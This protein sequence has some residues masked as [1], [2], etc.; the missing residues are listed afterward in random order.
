MKTNQ[1]L[2]ERFSLVTITGYKAPVFAAEATFDI[3]IKN[4][5]VDQA[6]GAMYG[7]LLLS[8]SSTDS[9]ETFLD[10]VNKLGANITVHCSDGMVTVSLKAL[11]EN[12]KAVISLFK[13][14]ITTPQ[15]AP[16][17][18]I[19]TKKWLINDLKEQAEDARALAHIQLTTTL[20]TKT[21]RRYTYS[22]KQLQ[23][24]IPGITRK[25][26][27]A[28]HERVSAS[29]VKASAVGDTSTHDQLTRCL[30]SL[31]KN[32]TLTSGNAIRKSATNPGT[33]QLLNV[34]SR[35]NIEYSIGAPLPITAHHPDFL[36]FWFGLNVLG[37]WGGFAGRLMS[38]VR[39]KEGLTYGIYARIES[40]SGTETSYWRIMS[41]FSPAN[42]VQGLNSTRREILKIVNDGITENELT[43]F[44]TILTTRNTLL[45]DSPTQAMTDIHTFHKAGFS[46][47]ERSE[48]IT[49]IQ[50][51]TK[52]EVD[53]ALKKYLKPATVTISGAGPIETVQNNLKKNFKCGIL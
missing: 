13:Q 26:L 1:I 6:L 37:K 21:D 35:Q 28:F 17:E 49:R 3:H 33:L 51:L 44:K 47:E 24:I 10:K 5:M 32:Q 31:P 25:Q 16:K 9:R 8:G 4:D 53:S 19:R 48:F 14:M 15:F 38:T 2:E 40:F 46:I 22:P 34:P 23:R 27:L 42:S 18:I 52:A 45:N 41:F 36:S 12:Q 43:R 29:F 20:F 7:E 39:E 11:A 50:R 30:R